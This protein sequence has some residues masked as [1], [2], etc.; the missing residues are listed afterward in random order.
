MIR[1]TLFFINTL[2]YK[3][4]GPESRTTHG[5]VVAIYYVFLNTSLKDGGVDD[6]LRVESGT[7]I[8]RFVTFVVK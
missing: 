5:Y 1:A 7:E 6:C 8:T 3:Q 4:F 2:V